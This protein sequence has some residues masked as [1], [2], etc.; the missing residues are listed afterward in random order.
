M[1]L[2]GRGSV[3]RLSCGVHGGEGRDC[4]RGRRG[5]MTLL[6]LCVP[7]TKLCCF[8][9]VGLKKVRRVA[10]HVEIVRASIACC[11]CRF[12]CE[13]EVVMDN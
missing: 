5:R 13:C 4:D 3:G 2:E 1:Q 6:L 11:E 10:S 7:R 12:G 9:G 8:L